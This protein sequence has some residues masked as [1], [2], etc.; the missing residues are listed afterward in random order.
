MSDECPVCREAWVRPR[1][2]PCGHSVCEACMRATDAAEV[3][4]QQQRQDQ[5]Q[6]HHLSPVHRCPLCRRE[7]ALPWS[8][9]P[10]NRAL[11][12][13]G[14]EEGGG[15]PE[16]G[17]DA[18]EVSLEVEE[19]GPDNLAALSLRSRRV[20]AAQLLEEVVPLL[21]DAAAR[22]LSYVVLRGETARRVFDVGG[23][24]TRA[25]FESH[26]VYGVEANKTETVIHI[27][28]SATPWRGI[29]VNERY[30]EQLLAE[31]EEEDVP[32]NPDSVSA[33]REQR[34]LQ[35]RSMVVRMLESVSE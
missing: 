27:I 6:H 19:A 5:P 13:T 30:A 9:R 11:L 21:R 33:L 14:P 12:C 2:F 31:T 10:L 3:H 26:G 23:A 4:Q 20:L 24:F 35:T 7:T 17:G 34:A 29:Y 25:L 32:G 8:L 1:L 16:D 15:G 28:A 18:E 22:G